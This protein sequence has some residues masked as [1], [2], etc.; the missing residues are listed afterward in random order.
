MHPSP[1]PLRVP[2]PPARSTAKVQ[3]ENIGRIKEWPR[4]RLIAYIVDG[5]ASRSV[6]FANDA[7]I[8]LARGKK[9]HTVVRPPPALCKKCRSI[10]A[11]PRLRELEHHESFHTACSLTPWTVATDIYSSVRSSVAHLDWSTAK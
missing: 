9:S 2:P 1:L 5:I 10:P 11:R 6:Y 4:A 8:H 7:R 3:G